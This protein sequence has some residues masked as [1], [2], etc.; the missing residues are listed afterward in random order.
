MKLYRRPSPMRNRF[1]FGCLSPFPLSARTYRHIDAVV[2]KRFH[3]R[4]LFWR[5]SVELA[6]TF[7]PFNCVQTV[8]FQVVQTVK[9][10]HVSATHGRRHND[11]HV[12]ER[13]H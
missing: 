5:V 11:V 3:G 2:R 12:L 6:A 1:F 4:I 13:R 10:R 8:A 7:I 9:L